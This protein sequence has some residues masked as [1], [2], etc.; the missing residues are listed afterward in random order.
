[1]VG[2]ESAERDDAVDE[3]VWYLFSSIHSA[4]PALVE[5]SHL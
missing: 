1:M 5:N 2:V 3:S 4:L